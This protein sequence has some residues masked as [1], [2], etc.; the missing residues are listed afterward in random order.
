MA[1][2]I[3]AL[4]FSMNRVENVIK[5]ANKLKDYVD[6]IVIVD[7]SSDQNYK[8]L[9]ENLDFCNIY[10]IPPIGVAELYYK[11]GMSLCKYDWILQF[12]DDEDVSVEDLKKIKHLTNDREAYR[13]KRA[14]PTDKKFQR[15]IR[16]YHKDSVVP[17]GLIHWV[18]AAKDN[19]EDV[20]FEII[21]PPF[22]SRRD[23][24]RQLKK[25]AVIESYQWGLKI[26]RSVF[27]TY[28][29]YEE[30]P[31]IIRSIA[32]KIFKIQSKLGKFGWYLLATE[33]NLFMLFNGIYQSIK[34]RVNPLYSL[35]YVLFIQWNITKSFSRKYRVWM[36]MIEV[37]DPI[38]YMHLESLED[39]KKLEKELGLSKTEGLKNFIKIV[40]HFAGLG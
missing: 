19:Y 34:A 7:Q 18:M 9:K 29:K 17:T 14:N 36:K 1:Q 24:I 4:I 33:Y 40:E 16:L 27:S 37:G 15:I 5:L 39:I 11:V 38:K 13:V 32:R 31:E 28:Q 26:V 22:Q 35:L 30:A 21:H 6:E 10:W 12:D 23:L 25:Y 20:D 3:S 2:K 8:K